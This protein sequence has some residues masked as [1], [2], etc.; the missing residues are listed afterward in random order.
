MSL[1]SVE[2]LSLRLGTGLELLQGISLHIDP[3]ETV[4][5]VGES[6]SGKSLT[7]RAVLGLFPGQS[8]V[9]GR[10][11]LS[12]VDMV[13]ADPVVARQQRRSEVSMVFQDPRA[14]V[15][16]VRRVGDFLTEALRQC[17]GWTSRGLALALSSCSPRSVSRNP[18]VRC[19]GTHTNCRAEC[20]N[21]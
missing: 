13:T 16:P 12:G 11:V 5:L 2:D 9:G 21:G 4:G 10:V 14:G 20:C 1:L 3:G 19:C 8:T 18:N 6:G 7:A 17:H 15:N